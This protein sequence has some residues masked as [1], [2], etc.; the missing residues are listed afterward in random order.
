MSGSGTGRDDRG[1][2][3]KIGEGAGAMAG[4]AA[5]M[6]MGMSATLMRSAAD[7]LSEWWSGSQAR[8][9]ANSWDDE[10]ERTSRQHFESAGADRSF[11]D[12]RPLYQF[13]H[14]AGQNPEY[15]GRSFSDVEP[16][17][18]RAWESDRNRSG[19][20]P[21]LRGYVGFGYEQNTRK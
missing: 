18:R 19:E 12:V 4:K 17:L 5:D 8:A 20:W 21:E 2:L 3:E 15:Q 14:V 10:Q 7:T 6:A 16:E 9:A 13:G 1:N 11:D